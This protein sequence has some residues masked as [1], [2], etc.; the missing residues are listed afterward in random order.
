MTSAT[1]ATSASDVV[2]RASVRTVST[3]RDSACRC[4]V[5]S[6]LSA[7]ASATPVERRIRRVDATTASTAAGRAK[8]AGDSG[9]SCAAAPTG[10]VCAGRGCCSGSACG[11]SCRATCTA[12]CAWHQHEFRRANSQVRFGSGRARIPVGAIDCDCGAPKSARAHC[13]NDSR[14]EQA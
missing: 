13:D 2:H 11:R 9:L 14:A 6:T 4:D 5:Y 7:Y 3:R 1:S 8:A 10:N 12:V